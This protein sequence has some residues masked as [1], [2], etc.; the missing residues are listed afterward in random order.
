MSNVAWVLKWL[1][2]AENDLLTGRR[3]LTDFH[4]KQLE[5]SCYQC[6]QA[7]EK[8]LKAYLVMQERA[9]PYVHDCRKLCL[10][11]AEY[12]DA[13]NEYTG[14]CADLTPYATRAR[15][16][17]DDEMDEPEVQAALRKAERI[18]NFCAS[19]ITSALQA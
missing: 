12:D 19:L 1:K 7:A 13:F 9:F 2:R 8:A 6:Q 5:I 18:V 15:Y 10:L 14:D 17:Q 16:P 4:P 3:L 11:C